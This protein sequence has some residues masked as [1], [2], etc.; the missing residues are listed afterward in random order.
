M[1]SL[2]GQFLIAAP[3]LQD[4]NFRRAVVLI[5]KHDADGALG[6]VLNRLA[7]LPFQTVWQKLSS[8]PCPV[9]APLFIGGP[10]GGPLM[11]LHDKDD[12]GDL[13]VPEGVFFTAE[14]RRIRELLT[15]EESSYRLFGGYSG[16]GPEQLDNEIEAG[17][18]LLA[19]AEP[20][21]IFGPHENLWEQVMLRLRE[22][23]RLSDLLHIKHV[24]PEPWM[25]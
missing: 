21:L 14:L 10:C 12:L 20:E 17:G 6:L 23:N 22:T 13:Q 2:A 5:L 24:P 18:W 15:R 25:N 19:P 11:A 7:P 3:S 9:E 4:P 16:W 8:E 1:N